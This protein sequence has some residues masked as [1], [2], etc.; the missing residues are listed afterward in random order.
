MEKWII[1]NLEWIIPFDKLEFTLVITGRGGVSPPAKKRL[2]TGNPSPTSIYLRGCHP[3]R[4]EVESKDLFG[5]TLLIRRRFFDSLRSL[6]MTQYT[7][8]FREF[9]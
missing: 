3:E 7:I 5:C 6:R 2:G 8:G 1:E 9:G 4:N